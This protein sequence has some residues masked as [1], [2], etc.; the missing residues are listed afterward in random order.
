MIV[1]V[2]ALSGVALLLEGVVPVVTAICVELAVHFALV[3]G[4]WAEYRI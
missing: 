1:L 3:I 2:V 4:G